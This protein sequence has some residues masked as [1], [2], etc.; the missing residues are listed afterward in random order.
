M[1]RVWLCEEHGL[2]GLTCYHEQGLLWMKGRF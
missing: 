1:L 2:R